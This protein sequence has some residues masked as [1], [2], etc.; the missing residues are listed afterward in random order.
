MFSAIW[1]LI[2]FFRLRSHLCLILDFDQLATLCFAAKFYKKSVDFSWNRKSSYR[3]FRTLPDRSPKL[4]AQWGTAGVW[5]QLRADERNIRGNHPARQTRTAYSSPI[6]PISP[7]QSPLIHTEH[8][9]FPHAL[10]S[11]S[12]TN[13]C[14]RCLFFLHLP[15][16]K[17][18]IFWYCIRFFTFQTRFLA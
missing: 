15:Q 17:W 16:V 13:V 11:F 6:P 18:K 7:T 10:R 3:D 1:T 4:S 9:L 5:V 14:R 2:T 8:S 12:T